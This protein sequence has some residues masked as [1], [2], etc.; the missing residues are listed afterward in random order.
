MNTDPCHVLAC[1]GNARIVG[2]SQA[3]DKP[4]RRTARPPIG[5]ESRPV[6]L[7]YKFSLCFHSRHTSL[8]VVSV[9]GR[10]DDA[11]HFGWVREG[12]DFSEQVSAVALR[13]RLKEVLRFVRRGDT[14]SASQT[15]SPEAPPTF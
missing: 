13:D 14:L 2:N 15:G 10:G 1:P 7:S 4:F 5:S 9:I 8:P 3:F 6:S 11:G 12:F